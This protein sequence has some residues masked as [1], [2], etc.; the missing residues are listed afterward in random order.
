MRTEKRIHSGKAQNDLSVN[1]PKRHTRRHFPPSISLA[2]FL[3]SSG[4]S[5][6]MHSAAFVVASGARLSLPST[7][8]CHWIFFSQLFLIFF[9]SRNKVL[10]HIGWHWPHL[11]LRASVCV[12]AAWVDYFHWHLSQYFSKTPWHRYWPWPVTAVTI[13]FHNQKETNQSR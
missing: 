4:N 2:H 1:F 9:F 5:L 13:Y 11:V 7:K 6:R 12:R 8:N 10:K 3:I